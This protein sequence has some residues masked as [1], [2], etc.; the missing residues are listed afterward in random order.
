MRSHQWFRCGR[1]I[2]ILFHGF[3]KLS[4]LYI[5]KYNQGW[6]KSQESVVKLCNFY[7]RIVIFL[8][9]EDGYNDHYCCSDCN[10]K[11]L[12][13]EKILTIATIAT[14]K[15]ATISTIRNI[16]SI[17]S[18]ILLMALSYPWY[19]SQISGFRI[20]EIPLSLRF[21]FH[22]LDWQDCRIPNSLIITNRTWRDNRVRQVYLLN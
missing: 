10:C 6:S 2:K 22:K 17:E 19:I 14:A 9:R 16:S 11:E 5:F 8:I 20:K 15:C 12:T 21:V 18:I 13:T 7:I 4:E 1:E 3:R